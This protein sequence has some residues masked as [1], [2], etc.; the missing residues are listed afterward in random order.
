MIRNLCKKIIS[1]CWCKTQ[2]NDEYNIFE[3]DV[4][5][6][7]V[8]NVVNNNVNDEKFH[9]TSTSVDNSYSYSLSNEAF[10]YS[11]VYR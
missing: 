11:D 5:N 1:Y 9:R 2:D 4:V 7:V 8:I 3:N 6:N 10:T